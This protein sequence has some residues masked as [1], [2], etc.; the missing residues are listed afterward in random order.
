MNRTWAMVQAG[1]P[2]GIEVDG[3]DGTIARHL[4]TVLPGRFGVSATSLSPEGAAWIHGGVE[5]MAA[6]PPIFLRGEGRTILRVEASH[7]AREF[8]LL[9]GGICC[10]L[11]FLAMLVVPHCHVSIVPDGAGG[12][13]VQAVSLNRPWRLR[14]RILAAVDSGE[15]LEWRTRR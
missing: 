15:S 3:A 10:L 5:G 13:L 9:V 14:T 6:A 1:A 4:T 2:L 7:N 8:W 11:G 12:H